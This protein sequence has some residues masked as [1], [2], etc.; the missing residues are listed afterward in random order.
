MHKQSVLLG[1]SLSRS[2]SLN[3]SLSISLYIRV[4]IT[5]LC[6]QKPRLCYVKIRCF[7]AKNKIRCLGFIILAQPV[8]DLSYLFILSCEHNLLFPFTLDYALICVLQWVAEFF[9]I[10]PIY[11]NI[12][13]N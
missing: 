9:P 11:K 5:N 1:S 3:I 7:E 2:L 12:D 4:D 6:V 8:L 10:T 13:P